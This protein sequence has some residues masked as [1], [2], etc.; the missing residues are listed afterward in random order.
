[1]ESDTFSANPIGVR[2]EPDKL[3]ERYLAG[4]PMNELV[5]QGSA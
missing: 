1:M 3:I 2:F 4:D 5:K